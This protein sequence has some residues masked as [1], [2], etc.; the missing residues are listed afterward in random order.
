MSKLTGGVVGRETAYAR[1][2]IIKDA[3]RR[4]QPHSIAIQ[5]SAGVD[6]YVAEAFRKPA[7]ATTAALA[8]RLYEQNVSPLTLLADVLSRRLFDSDLTAVEITP[9]LEFVAKE[10]EQLMKASSSFQKLNEKLRSPLN[11]SKLS[12]R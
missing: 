10:A 2:A 11:L 3:I 4:L 6:Q 5:M 1:I 7:E 9:L 12:G 8:I